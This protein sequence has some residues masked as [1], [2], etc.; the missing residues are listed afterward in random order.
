MAWLSRAMLAAAASLTL[1]ARVEA[2]PAGP[3]EADFTGWQRVETAHFAFVFEPR[4][5]GAVQ[6]LLS[7]SE[8][9]YDEVTGFLGSRPARVWVVIAG[10]VDLANGFTSPFPPHITLYL[11]PPSEP[12]IG[13]EASQYLRLLLV[14]ELTHFIN[15]EYD[16]GMFAFLSAFFG[17]GSQGDKRRLFAN[18]VS[19]RDSDTYGNDLHRRRA[20]EKSF[21]RD[22]IPCLR[23]LTPLF[24]VEP[25]RIQLVFPALR[26]GLDWRLFVISLHA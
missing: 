25:S 4:D 6:E 26:P 19:G 8:E 21:F 9:V 1:I 3:L 23:A 14:H 11:A 18:V 2:N 16:K 17:P 22:G 7:F 20:R 13:L 12:L 24:S 15:F 10:R 5:Q